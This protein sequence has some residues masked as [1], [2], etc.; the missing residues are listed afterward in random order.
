MKLEQR[1]FKI[2]L[3]SFRT[4]FANFYHLQSIINLCKSE[5]SQYLCIQR[6]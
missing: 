4:K 3:D 5:K 2:A 1:A 6:Y